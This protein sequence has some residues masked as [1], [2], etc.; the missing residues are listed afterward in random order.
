MEIPVWQRVL[1]LL[2]YLLPWSDAIPFGVGFN[3]VFNQIPVLRLLT[4]PAIPF[5]ALD[6]LIPYGLGGLLLFFVLLFAVVRNA[7]VPYFIRFN[8]LQ[9]LLI[10]IVLIALGFAING[11]LAPMLPAGLLLST[12]KSAVVVAVLAIW[13]FATIECVRGREPD[14]PGISP[15]VR[16]QLY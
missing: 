2:V 15:A 9:A 5:F 4:I 14:L 8:T 13:I 6:Q 1:G 7:E 11:I 16:M 12:L 3:G 10:D